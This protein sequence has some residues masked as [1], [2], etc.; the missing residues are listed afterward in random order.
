MI[1]LASL[2]AGAAL[3]AAPALADPEKYVLDSSHS[4]IVF[5]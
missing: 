4:Q 2:T 3:L 1:R 5:S